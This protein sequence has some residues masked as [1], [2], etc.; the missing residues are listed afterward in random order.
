MET[1]TYILKSTAILGIFYVIYILV[2]R[3]DTFFTANRH[4]L[5]GGVL[6]ALLLPFVAFETITYIPAPVVEKLPFIVDNTDA[7]WEALAPTVTE[8]TIDW[9]Q[10]LLVIYS[11]GVAIMMIRFLF[12]LWSLQRLINSGTIITKNRFTY[13]AVSQNVTPFSFFKYIVYNPKLHTREE[14][15]MILAHEQVHA[16]QLHSI[17]VLITQI[18]LALQWCNPIAWLYKNTIEQ[19]L[20]YIADSTAA[21]QVQSYK[22]YQRTLVKVSSTTYRPAL[23]TNFYHSFIKKRIVM[24]NKPASQRRNLLKLGLILPALALFMYSFHTKEIIQFEKVQEDTSAFAK[25]EPANTLNVTI[26]KNFVLDDFN[27][28]TVDLFTKGIVFITNNVTRNENGTI[29][30]MQVITHPADGVKQNRYT[31]VEKTPGEGIE[32]ATLTFDEETLEATITTGIATIDTFKVDE[33]GNIN[34]GKN[35]TGIQNT[36]GVDATTTAAD[37]DRI[38]NMVAQ[39]YP[40]SQFRFSDRLFDNSGR[41]IKFSFQTKFNNESKFSTRFTRDITPPKIWAGYSV[42]V[43][44]NN[45]IVVEE[46]GPK[47]V[48]LKIS[49]EIIS[50]LEGGYISPSMSG[51]TVSGTTNKSNYQDIYRFKITKN[52]SIEELQALKKMLKEEHNATLEYSNVNFNAQNEITSIQLLFKDANGNS[53]NYSNSSESPISDIFIYRDADGSTGMGNAGSRAEMDERMVEMKARMQERRS[54]M[55]VQSQERR[56]QMQTQIEERKVQMEKKRAERRVYGRAQADKDSNNIKGSGRLYSQEK[57]KLKLSEYEKLDDS[58]KPLVVLDG[59]VI[60]YDTMNTLDPNHIGHMNIL[61]GEEALVSYGESGKYGAIE[62]TTKSNPKYAKIKKIAPSKNQFTVDASGQKLFLI[63]S[64][65]GIKSNANFGGVT[66]AKIDKNSTDRD[67]DNL[68]AAFQKDNIT[69]QKTTVSRNAKGEI[70]QI[71]LIMVGTSGNRTSSTFGNK[72]KPIGTI[73]LGY[74]GNQ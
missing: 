49:D 74:T 38:E 16:S 22:E 72:K 41:L 51:S 19:N 67:I 56:E 12:Q 70:T 26:K 15:E 2:L 48:S 13:I 1:L 20:E 31:I 11:I 35:A 46:K 73:W 25:A 28:I 8:F 24:L 60:Q 66:Q 10:V 30:S 52:T 71:T 14:Q 34:R 18:A 64:D 54:K 42:Q 53:K 39:N 3:R 50:F 7:Q 45:E 17:D 59:K 62:I 40:K 27:E 43:T 37:L 47:G 23:T 68:R 44:P 63:Q 33:T 29:A 4:Y 36:F 21:Q 5:I 61:K 69:V 58:K 6:A 32:D 9:F 65:T 55:E 57:S